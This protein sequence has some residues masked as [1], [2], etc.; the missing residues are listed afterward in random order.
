MRK[1]RRITA[2][3]GACLIFGA[4]N[5]GRGDFSGVEPMTCHEGQIS[6]HPQKKL[7]FLKKQLNIPATDVNQ[8]ASL[9]VQ[10][11]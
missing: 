6:N 11:V 4:S 10:F 8:T 9:S 7:Q 3:T 5:T 1:T 2:R